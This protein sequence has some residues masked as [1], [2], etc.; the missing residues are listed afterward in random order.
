[1]VKAALPLAVALLGFAAAAAAVAA[2]VGDVS[3]CGHPEACIFKPA[4]SGVLWLALTADSQSMLHGML[5]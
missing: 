5:A 3:T 2:G 1:M 4:V